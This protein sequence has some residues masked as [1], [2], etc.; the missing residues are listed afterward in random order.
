MYGHERRPR[1]RALSL[2]ASLSLS[3]ANAP[4][5]RGQGTRARVRPR[6][7]CP[8]LIISSLDS[9]R[10][11]SIFAAPTLRSLIVTEFRGFR[12]SCRRSTSWSARG[13]QRRSRKTDSP[14][15]QDCPQKRG[16][17]VRVYTTTPEEAELGPAQ[18]RPRA[19]H[20]RHGSDGVHPWRGP[21]SSRALRG[22]DPR[23]PRE[24]S[25]GRSLSRRARNA[26]CVGAAGPSNTNK[27]ERTQ[28]RSKYGVK[29]RRSG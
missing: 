16:V 26:R 23:R 1:T 15:L 17:C 8:K 24:G 20:Q 19:S 21:Q 14:A 2:R 3:L 22:A 12:A 25:A 6:Y 27:L 7:S 4:S 29:R 11:P 5:G 28:G 18:G 13:A 10:R 9:R